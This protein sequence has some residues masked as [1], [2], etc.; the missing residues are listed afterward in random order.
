MSEIQELEN[1]CNGTNR[2]TETGSHGEMWHFL[3]PKQK[4]VWTGS[5]GLHT[6]FP[7]QPAQ[8]QESGTRAFTFWSKG[9]HNKP[10]GAVGSMPSEASFIHY[11]AAV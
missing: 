7:N 4:S 2:S 5:R 9:G 6:S 10:L 8:T 11:D 3:Q 1:R